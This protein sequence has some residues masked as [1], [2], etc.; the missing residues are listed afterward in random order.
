MIEALQVRQ[1]AR[2]GAV[3]GVVVG[4]LAYALFVVVRGHSLRLAALYVVSVLVVA[5]ATTVLVTVVLVA[6]R[7]LG[8]TVDARRWIRRGGTAALAGGT[9]LGTFAL[10]GPLFGRAT[11]SVA[12][13]A[14][15]TA[16]SNL[17]T[18]VLTLYGWLLPACVAAVLAGAWAIHAAHRPQPGYGRLGLAGWVLTAPAAVFAWWVTVVEAGAFL[19]TALVRVTPVGL[20]AVLLALAAGTSL[21]GAAAL[22]TQSM[23]VR[24]PLVALFALPL[25][26]A[27]LTLTAVVDPGGTGVVATYLDPVAPP[28]AALALPVAVA[29][30]LLGADLRAGRGVPPADSFGIDLAAEVAPEDPTPTT[31]DHAP[32]P[33]RSPERTD[34]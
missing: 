28:T 1:K 5:S 17:P 10:L 4:L 30:A 12:A 34:D 3:V 31:E 29:W 15:G 8:A 21:L 27:G 26:L 33:D 18:V 32:D 2:V 24:G 23:P 20:L 11:G 7:L 6:R 13:T 16:V 9:L 25:S 14:S 19:G 22:R